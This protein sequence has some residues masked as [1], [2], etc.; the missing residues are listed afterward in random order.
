MDAIGPLIAASVS[1]RLE[2]LPDQ[3]VE[4]MKLGILDTFAAT[5]AGY[6]REY[7][8]ADSAEIN[9]VNR[10]SLEKRIRERAVS[11]YHPVGTCRMGSDPSAVVAPK[12]RVNGVT[13][14]RV[15]DASIMPGLINGNT[16][17]PTIMIAEK[18]RDDDAGMMR[19]GH[20]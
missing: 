14:L 4:R 18:G 19:T 12:L 10:A 2:Y 11:V 15:V 17:A 20:G 7:I 16:N 13:G 8:K 1:L 3:V 5:V 9:S 6:C